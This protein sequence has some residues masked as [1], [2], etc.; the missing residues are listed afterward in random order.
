ML[1]GLF[2]KMVIADRAAVIVDTV[3][4][5]SAAYSVFY[6]VVV[7]VFFAIQIYCDFYGYSTVVR[8]SALLMGIKLMDK[9]IC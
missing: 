5:N 9:I 2:L 7:T 8:G 6:I 3:Y 1:Y 4:R